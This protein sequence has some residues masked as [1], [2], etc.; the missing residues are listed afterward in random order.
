[1][2]AAIF[3]VVLIIFIITVILHEVA[4]HNNRPEFTHRVR[5]YLWHTG[6]GCFVI[7]FAIFWAM[8]IS[9]MMCWEERI[10]L[11]WETEMFDG[12]IL[13]EI[14]ENKIVYVINETG[15]WET[16]WGHNALVGYEK[17]G[18]RF[19]NVTQTPF[20]YKMG[21]G[22]EGG[23]PLTYFEATWEGNTEW[24]EVKCR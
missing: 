17:E 22:Q 13:V 18:Q 3:L 5:N 15:E 21:L 10:N 20:R 1:M 14:T 12:A 6:D 9:G 24:V 8:I 4:N 16:E 7:S 19:H 11:S 2:W 23:C